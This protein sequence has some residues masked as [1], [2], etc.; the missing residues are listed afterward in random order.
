MASLR[1]TACYA[2]QLLASTA[3][4][5]SRAMLLRSPASVRALSGLAPTASHIS[6]KDQSS[7]LTGSTMFVEKMGFAT[8]LSYADFTKQDSAMDEAQ[9]YMEEGVS[10]LNNDMIP[11]AMSCFQR[12][13]NVRP[14]AAAHYNMGIGYFQLGDFQSSIK[15][16]QESLKLA[17]HHA[18]VHTNLATAH[19][20]HDGNMAEALR[21][22][23]AAA[24]I[25]SQGPEIQ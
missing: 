20:K 6:R 2:R 1:T 8:S 18:D 21:H 16:F 17:P 12:S 10:F 5:S 11:M 7:A 13:L 9:E 3:R 22:L 25:S 14:T 24:N 15:A 19:I 23:Q 4:G